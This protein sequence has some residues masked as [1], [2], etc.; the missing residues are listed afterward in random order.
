MQRPSIRAGHL[1]RASAKT[2]SPSSVHRVSS[3]SKSAMDYLC[4]VVNIH[5]VVSIDALCTDNLTVSLQSL[6]LEKFGG[7]QKLKTIKK[8]KSLLEVG[9]Q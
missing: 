1:L 7:R 8:K 2:A 5:T 3:G 9:R 4:V 6:Q